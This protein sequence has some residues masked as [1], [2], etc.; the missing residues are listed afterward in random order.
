MT[1]GG[2]DP[3]FGY[4]QQAGQRRADLV[5]A[6]AQNLERVFGADHT[7]FGKDRLV[8]GHQLVLQF[9]RA[10]IVPRQCGV[11]E[12]GAELRRDIGGDRNAAM[13]AVG[14]I[15]KGR[16]IL[17]R[18]L[19]EI[20]AAGDALLRNAGDV[21]GCVLHPRDARQFRQGAH[22]FGRHVDD[23]TAGDVID[24]DRDIAGIVDSGVM[25]NQPALRRL[26]VIGRDN[27]RTVRADLF[28]ELHKP[29]G[30]D[31]V[32][33]SGTGNDRHATVGGLHDHLDDALVFLVRQGRRFAGGADGDQPVRAFGDMPFYE[34]LQRVF[35]HLAVG[36]RG[37][38]SGHGTF[39]HDGLRRMWVSRYS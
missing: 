22:G 24:D 28:G 5:T 19:D 27:Q 13:P 16:G 37:D 18:K 33:R 39:E 8:Q 35:V 32:V 29:D 6:F 17:A 38:K 25:R 26:V 2:L 3:G 1:H 7:R 34:G 9:Q 10:G 30:L 15:A 23:R 36:K 14:V 21:A 31:R 11:L 20:R 4:G 12:F